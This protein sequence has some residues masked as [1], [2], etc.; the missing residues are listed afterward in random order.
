MTTVRT[1]GVSTSAMSPASTNTT[2]IG[3]TAL[4]TFEMKVI[5]PRRAVVR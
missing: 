4:P 3:P 2:T 1:K 5:E